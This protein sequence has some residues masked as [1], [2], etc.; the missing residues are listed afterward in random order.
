MK[1]C[2]IIMNITEGPEKKKV[3]TISAVE[4]MHNLLAIVCL[5]FFVCLHLT[6]HIL[7]GS[8]GTIAAC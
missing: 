2:P 8:Y 6:E 7:H 1:T 3:S 4:S 5:C